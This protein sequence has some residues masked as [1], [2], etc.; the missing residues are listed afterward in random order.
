MS[1]Q[2]VVVDANARRRLVRRVRSAVR[3]YIDTE[4]NAGRT[5]IK[6]SSGLSVT[7]QKAAASVLEQLGFNCIKAEIGE[8][9]ML[10]PMR[11]CVLTWERFEMQPDEKDG[12][13]KKRA[14]VDAGSTYHFVIK[15]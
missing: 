11:L 15:C 7:A 6:G 5:I 2:R 10:A 13:T 12:G 3:C 4:K 1:G 9:M 8:C 14:V